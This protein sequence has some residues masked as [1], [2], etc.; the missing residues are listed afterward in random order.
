MKNIFQKTMVCGFGVFVVAQSA[1]AAGVSEAVAKQDV[2]FY[3]HEGVTYQFPADY[4]QSH[5][6]LIELIASGEDVADYGVNVIDSAKVAEQFPEFADNKKADDEFSRIAVRNLSQA[7]R[8]YTSYI[9]DYDASFAHTCPANMFVSG[10]YSVHSNHHEDRRFKLTCASV[11]AGSYTAT[12]G[13]RS[14]TGYVNNWDQPVNF[15][16]PSNKFIVGVGSYHSN[17]AEDRRF[18]FACAAMNVK[19][20][21]AY[22]T[23]CGSTATSNWDAVNNHV[24]YSGALTGIS[25]YHHNHYED[26]RTSARYCNAVISN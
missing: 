14:W 26:R 23:T 16:C 19:G 24:T 21:T 8:Y 2:T 4:E 5:E 20:G 9:N 22:P 13:S 15:T 17:R 11:K 1:V 7:S 12:R 25:S 10:I 18:R 3:Q 6:V